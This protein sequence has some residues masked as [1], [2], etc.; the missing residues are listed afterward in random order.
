MICDGRHD[1]PSQAEYLL[2]FVVRQV[3]WEHI[4]L[5]LECARTSIPGVLGQ[6]QPPYV[7][8]WITKLDGFP[9]PEWDEAL[10]A[11]L[12]SPERR[13]WLAERPNFPTPAP[14]S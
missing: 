8:G 11:Y 3:S 14:W 13:A 4:P 9:W 1:P 2:T 12:I 7:E 10:A 5:C 6:Q